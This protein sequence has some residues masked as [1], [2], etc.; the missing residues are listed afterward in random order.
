[1]SGM[2]IQAF[3]SYSHLDMKYKEKL[4]KHFS[5]IS[6]TYDIEL[7]HDGCIKAGVDINEEVL[8]KLRVSNLILLLLSPA[9][10]DSDFCYNIEMKKAFERY[11]EGK[12]LIVP[13]LIKDATLTK[14][15]PFYSLKTLP[16]DRKPLTSFKPQD[17][18]CV[19]I[20]GSLMEL[21]EEFIHAPDNLH[22]ENTLKRT[23][24]KSKS[25]NSPL[26]VPLC[27]KGKV[28]TYKVG[29]DLLSTIIEYNNLLIDFS[30]SIHSSVV[31]HVRKYAEKV[32]STTGINMSQRKRLFRSFLL[33]VCME[34]RT[35]LFNLGGVRIHFRGLYSDYYQCIMAWDEKDRS[36]L[37][38][39]WQN[40]LTP[41]SM[42]SMISLSAKLK[43]PL[44]KSFNKE[45]HEKGTHDDIWVDYISCAL[46][47]LDKSVNPRMSFGISVHKNYT[48]TYKNVLI[49]LAVLRIDKTIERT[50]Q[51]YIMLC[52]EVDPN[53][54][55]VK[56]IKSLCIT[57][58]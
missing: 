24:G 47:G 38:V 52:K 29:Q 43:Y 19:D 12:C 13:I 54:N 4:L 14:S 46:N 51:S 9:Y 45:Y 44:I 34:V 35:K 20:T 39:E 55:L 2:K 48:T 10:I 1:M 58:I 33:D 50:L 6:K 21:I 37:N 3:I 25:N 42:N 27:K 11:K 22:T 31:V 17:R 40:E 41:M 57:H 53:Y 30:D 16:T 8:K 23:K 28:A 56:M 36:S 26:Y 49:A 5:S 18:G 15:M 32:R 7:W